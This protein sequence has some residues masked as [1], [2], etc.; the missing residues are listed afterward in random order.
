[1]IKVSTFIEEIILS[2][3]LKISIQ[4]IKQTKKIDLHREILRQIKLPK[5]LSKKN[6][7]MYYI[8]Q[9]QYAP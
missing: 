9:I 2:E 7:G 3:S 4:F 5:D 8:P 6:P 1:M